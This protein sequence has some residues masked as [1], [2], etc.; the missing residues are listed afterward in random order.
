MKPV[1]KKRKNILIQLFGFNLGL[2][3]F[4]LISIYWVNFIKSSILEYSNIKSDP[5]DW[6]VKPITYIP[7]WLK[8]KNTN[9]SLNFQDESLTIDEF[10]ELP[11]Y[12]LSSLSDSS[13][14]NKEA[15]IARYTFPVV[16]M[17]NY[18]LDYEEFAGSHPAVDI[19]APIWTPVL[20]IANWVVV[21]VKL[22][23][24]WD[25]KYVIIRHDDVTINWNTET[26]YSS[27]LHLSDI[28]VEAWS[29]IAKWDVLGKVW[30]TW[31]TTTPHLHFQIDKKDSPFHPFWPFTFREAMDLWLDFFWAINFWLGK[32]NAISYTI[33]PMEFVQ[34]YLS[35][36][37]LNSAPIIDEVKAI[38][39]E[40]VKENIQKDNNLVADI[41]NNLPS[42]I[43]DNSSI[44]WL[45]NTNL[46][47]NISTWS[48]MELSSTWSSNEITAMPINTEKP[49]LEEP[50]K[51]PTKISNWNIF[52]DISKTSKLYEPTKYLKENKITAWYPDGSF[53]PNWYLTRNEALIFV[54]KLYNIELDWNMSLPFSDIKKSDFIVPYLK[55]ALELQL[56]SRNNKF[57]PNDK[58][59]KAE[60]VTIL[61]KASWREVLNTWNTPFYDINQTDWYSPYVETFSSVFKTTATKKIKFEPN[62]TFTRWQI[63]QILYTFAKNK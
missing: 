36:W 42:N 29:K 33:H 46:S 15:I 21:K 49:V 17:W 38:E 43:Q 28:F 34:N 4:L 44:S 57:R 22:T 32:E 9:K 10:I 58:I 13:W 31:I 12:N 14:K 55:K 47:N 23:E 26:L 41:S 62:W 25:G 35:V 37:W 48:S 30:M 50:K 24:S 63:S 54:F 45:D 1:Y 3:L 51:E 52:N 59:S 40:I 16:Y 18:K 5:F 11:D 60:F 56:I 7:N 19:R 6:T 8:T 39:N 61:I 27:Y 20:S 2:F 53:K